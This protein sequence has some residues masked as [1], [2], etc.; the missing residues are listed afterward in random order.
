[1]AKFVSGQREDDMGQ[2]YVNTTDEVT[3]SSPVPN[4]TSPEINDSNPICSSS[5]ITLPLKNSLIFQNEFVAHFNPPAMLDIFGLRVY[6]SEPPN[7]HEMGEGDQG[8]HSV[9]PTFWILKSAVKSWV[10]WQKLS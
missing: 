4:D 1:M 2:H 10:I 6:I 7:Y 5:S 3:N 9:P 8:K